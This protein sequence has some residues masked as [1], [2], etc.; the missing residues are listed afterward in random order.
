VP[1]IY[2]R[3]DRKD[4]REKEQEISLEENKEKPLIDWD[5]ESTPYLY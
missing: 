4:K 5:W 2:E 1:D 3:D